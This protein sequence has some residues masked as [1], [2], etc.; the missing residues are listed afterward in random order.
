MIFQKFNYN[1][2]PHISSKDLRYIEEDP[3][4]RPFY[5]WAPSIENIEK[6]VQAK[7]EQILSRDLICDILTKQYKHRPDTDLQFVQI[8]KLR[9]D[10]TFTIVTAHQP[11][12]LT[13]PLYY[14]IKIFSAIKIAKKAQEK[15]P[16]YNFIPLF[17][18]GGED[19]DFEEMNHLELFGKNIEWKNDNFNG[20][21][22]G[23]LNLNGLTEVLD[24]AVAILGEDKPGGQ[25]I[26]DHLYELASN[27]PNY[28]SFSLDLTH[29]LFKKYGLLVINMDEPE[30]KK[31]FIPIILNEVIHNGSKSIIEKSQEKLE[32]IDWKL[33]AYVREINFFY[34]HDNQRLRIEK[35]GDQYKL[36]D[37]GISWSEAELTKEI[38]ANPGAF[39]PNVNMRPLFQEMMLPNVVFVGGGGEIA[40]WLERKEQFEHYNIP[41]PMIVRRSSLSIISPSI[42][43]NV[44]KLKTNL[45]FFFQDEHQL[46]NAFLETKDHDIELGKQ[47][48]GIQELM[49]SVAEIAKQTDPTLEKYTLAEAS[50]IQKIIENIESKIRKAIKRSEETDLNKLIKIKGQLFPNNG[51]QERQQNIFQ[52]IN[53]FG[54]EILEDIYSAVD[55]FAKEYVMISK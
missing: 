26:K 28:G 44:N 50:K 29:L 37:T 21:S 11:T 5:K 40:Y 33:Q 19:H 39:S 23:H 1:E 31:E 53:V 30:L 9:Q 17:I 42:T 4:V 46:V 6:V 13:G 3:Q 24:Q 25:W 16:Q 7:K 32:S 47:K 20:G 36:L 51:L 38:E 34:R 45:A 22:V 27:S 8:E 43:K 2:I 54:L 48:N 49:V 41:Y 15:F 10:D 52:F 35:E 55:P 12:L 14:I 18:S